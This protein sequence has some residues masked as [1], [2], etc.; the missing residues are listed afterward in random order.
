MPKDAEYYCKDCCI[1]FK[2]KPHIHKNLKKFN[3][4]AIHPRCGNDNTNKVGE[5]EQKRHNN[6]NDPPS[7]AQLEYIK[8][9][10]GNPNTPK[11]KSEAGAYISA[12]KKVKQQN[13]Q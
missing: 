9:L 7:T 5:V 11:T 8:G 3:K 12:L 10:G 6:L 13:R 4:K 1:Y 2:V